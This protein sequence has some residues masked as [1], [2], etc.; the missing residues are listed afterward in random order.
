MHKIKE[1]YQFTHNKIDI[2]VKIDY[3][4]NKISLKEPVNSFGGFQIKKWVFA[5]RG[6]EFM[7]GWLDILE[8]MQEAIKDAKLKYEHNLAEESKFKTDFVLNVLLEDKKRK[9]NK[10]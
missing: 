4:N 3:L 6:V 9:S 7:Q 8:A 1:T 2:Y 5:E 10:E